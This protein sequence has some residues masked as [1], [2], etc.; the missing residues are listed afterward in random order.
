MA[1]AQS[2]VEIILQAKNLADR[3]FQDAIRGLEGVEGAGAGAAKGLGDTGQ[4]AERA[5]EGLGDAAEQS[6][7]TEEVLRMLGAV[8]GKVSESID[9]NT[10]ALD[11]NQKEQENAKKGGESLLA[12]LDHLTQIWGALQRVASAAFGA[13]SAGMQR[14]AAD[15][16]KM[17]QS[18]LG[19]AAIM[20]KSVDSVASAF[21]R[22]FA[23]ALAP[24]TKGIADLSGATARWVEQNDVGRKSVVWVL[25][26][27]GLFARVVDI[28]IHMWDQFVADLKF[29]WVEIG[30]YFK[31]GTAEAVDALAFLVDKQIAF[32]MLLGRDTTELEKQY[33]ALKA[34]ADGYRKAADEIQNANTVLGTTP[35]A[36]G[37]A[38]DALTQM[39]DQAAAAG[40][41]MADSYVG[42][43]EQGKKAA[44]EELRWRQEVAS[45]IADTTQIALDAAAEVVEAD[46][47]KADLQAETRAKE[48]ED[49]ERD[50]KQRQELDKQKQ[51]HFEADLERMTEGASSEEEATRIRIAAMQNEL[52]AAEMLTDRRIQLE[53]MLAAE[54]KKQRA[55]EIA[56]ETAHNKQIIGLG[57]KLADELIVQK[58]GFVKTIVSL[59]QQAANSQ[60]QALSEQVSKEMV[61]YNQSLQ[62]KSAADARKMLLDKGSIASGIAAAMSFLG[63]LAPVG[64]AVVIA[65]M[66]AL[67]NKFS[68]VIKFAEGGSVLDRLGGMVGGVGGGDR[69]PAL[70]SP[71]EY[72]I[73]PESAQ[74]LGKPGLDYANAT[75][76]WPVQAAAGAGGGQFDLV[77]SFRE[78]SSPLVRELM[79]L[80]NFEV[81]HR[82]GR[83]TATDRY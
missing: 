77:V 20:Q 69:V 56:A 35:N 67:V 8:V 42:A 7:R 70:V 30:A 64:A 74:R 78:P 6:E 75:G 31:K 26:A 82:G 37:A 32:Q 36:A 3:A 50:L 57:V 81:T 27:L 18:V 4:G 51:E 13:I 28:T 49:A 80:I 11:K 55:Q 41:A 23:P 52:A 66:Y 34:S 53:K 73:R 9:R 60:I 33:M 47:K 38:A 15:G 76:Q 22:T 5:G 44:E 46:Q 59:A 58:K 62:T 19:Q 39:A 43:S 72:M 12:K 54:Q 65:A 16:D 24:V 17:A 63:P 79:K 45:S 14:A 71:L 83:L 61:L 21:A 29:S 25:D 1:N 10:A 68:S 40:Q 48:Q 2:T